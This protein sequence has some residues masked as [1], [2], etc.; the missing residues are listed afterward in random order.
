M[1]NGTHDAGRP[2]EYAGDKLKGCAQSG[3]RVN[4]SVKEPE[5]HLV[6][7]I[8]VPSESVSSACWLHWCHKAAVLSLS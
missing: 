7:R 4:R 2:Q 3:L 6:E 1:N 8:E 5:A